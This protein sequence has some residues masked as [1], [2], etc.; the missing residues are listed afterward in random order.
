MLG[1]LVAALTPDVSRDGGD[2]AVPAEAA[3]FEA[4]LVDAAPV[5]AMRDEVSADDELKDGE[6][7]TID[8]SGRKVTPRFAG[9][10]LSLL[11]SVEAA[12]VV[13]VGS[14][15]SGLYDSEADLPPPKDRVPRLLMSLFCKLERIE[16]E[17]GGRGRER[18][19]ESVCVF[20]FKR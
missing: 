15:F 20:L 9:L 16:G 1:T 7:G 4:A 13:L 12:A 2:Q 6:F 5:D 14:V 19:R 10:L 8:N 11:E 3:P 18:E 17:E